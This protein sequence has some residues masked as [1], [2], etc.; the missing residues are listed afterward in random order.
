MFLS[1]NVYYNQFIFYHNIIFTS[2]N[3]KF[4]SNYTQKHK[5]QILTIIHCIGNERREIDYKSL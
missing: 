3:G 4:I 2:F 5:V 1:W